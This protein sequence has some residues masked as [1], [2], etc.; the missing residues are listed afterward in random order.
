MEDPPEDGQNGKW[1]GP[2]FDLPESNQ[3][4]KPCQGDSANL[5]ADSP[6]FDFSCRTVSNR[7]NGTIPPHLHDALSRC[8]WQLYDLALVDWPSD[9]PGKQRYS[10]TRND[11]RLKAYNEYLAERREITPGK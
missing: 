11:D 8:I 7:K 9:G 3:P 2:N 10:L 1:L 4:G 5:P 6:P